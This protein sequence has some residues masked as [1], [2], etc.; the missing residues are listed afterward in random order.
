MPILGTSHALF[1]LRLIYGQFLHLLDVFAQGPVLLE[2]E[3]LNHLYI[4]LSVWAEDEGL[5]AIQEEKWPLYEDLQGLREIG[6]SWNEFQLAQALRLETKITKA[7]A[8]ADAP[9]YEVP[10]EL[11]EVFDETGANFFRYRERVERSMEEDRARMLKL[12]EKFQKAGGAGRQHRQERRG[13]PGAP[14]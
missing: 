4:V 6:E 10:K 13:T 3:K 12:R 7:Y 9:E 2:D 11:Q 5:S 8:R 14:S 1:L